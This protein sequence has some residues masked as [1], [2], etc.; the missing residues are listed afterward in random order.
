MTQALAT[1]LEAPA[2]ITLFDRISYWAR[3][4]PPAVLLVAAVAR[5]AGL[6]YPA[7]LVFDETYYV[8]DAWSL[9]HLGYEGSWIADAG[10]AGVPRPAEQPGHR[11]VVRGRAT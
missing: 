10:A 2:R 4:G 3:Y 1:A 7:K 6:G 11:R 9:V 5:L 8:K